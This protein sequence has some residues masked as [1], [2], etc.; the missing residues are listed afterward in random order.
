MGQAHVR[1]QQVTVL[2]LLWRAT[3]L[4]AI[5]PVGLQSRNHC[6]DHRSLPLCLIWK[7]RII[8]PPAFHL[9]QQAASG[10]VLQ[11][12]AQCDGSL[13]PSCS[14]GNASVTMSE[15]IISPEI[16]SFC[17]KEDRQC[18]LMILSSKKRAKVVHVLNPFSKLYYKTNISICYSEIAN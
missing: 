8:S 11:H 3:R 6:E 4:T 7:G 15:N 10:S 18:K 5:S 12:V 16:I 9:G 2:L 1:S 17:R 14:P 13:H